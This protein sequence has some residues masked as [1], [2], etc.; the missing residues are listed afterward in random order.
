MSDEKYSCE[1][2]QAVLSSIY[3]QGSA[4]ELDPQLKA[5]VNLY[6]KS[7]RDLGSNHPELIDPDLLALI[8]QNDHIV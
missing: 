6:I 7:M 8:Q 5:D 3:G 2:T 1:L 4:L